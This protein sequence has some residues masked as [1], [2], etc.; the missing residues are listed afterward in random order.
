MAGLVAKALG[1][2]S[3]QQEE[4]QDRRTIRRKKWRKPAQ[5]LASRRQAHGMTTGAADCN[6]A[7]F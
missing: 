1:R 6:A 5:V 3:E 4:M 7:G 2:N